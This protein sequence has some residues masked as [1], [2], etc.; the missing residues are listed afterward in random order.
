[1]AKQLIEFHRD[2]LDPTQSA[3]PHSFAID[4]A[5]FAIDLS[6]ENFARLKEALAPFIKVARKGDQSRRAAALPLAREHRKAMREWA[7]K[8]GYQ[9]GEKGRIPFEVEA[10]Y[11]QAMVA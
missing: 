4:G 3:S 11:A 10:A 9:V 8:N 6:E 1:M 7:G 5:V 2:D